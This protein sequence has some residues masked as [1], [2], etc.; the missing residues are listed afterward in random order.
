MFPASIS[1]PFL[2]IF[3]HFKFDSLI[4]VNAVIYDP[5]PAHHFFFRGD[6]ERLVHGNVLW[7]LVVLGS[8]FA[9]EK[10]DYN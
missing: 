1:S 10:D 9:S 6:A 4:S 3:D 2:D 5:S 8:H 7:F